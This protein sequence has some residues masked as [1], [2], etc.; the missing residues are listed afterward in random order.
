MKTT[1]KI[2]ILIFIVAG[3]AKE[4]ILEFDPQP[5]SF[6]AAKF[7]SP[8]TQNEY[9]LECTMTA[10][11]TSIISLS[12]FTIKYTIENNSEVDFKEHIYISLALV[13]NKPDF[14]LG[15]YVADYYSLL[16]WE[17]TSWGRTTKL[18]ELSKNDEYENSVNIADI[19]WISSISSAIQPANGNFYDL[20]QT[21]NFKFQLSI[22]IDDKDDYTTETPTMIYSN[23]LDL[24][25][26]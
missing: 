6:A 11:E 3:C 7:G 10:N 16:W 14:P 4:E 5:E 8:S 18:F 12:D 9:G 22:M 2:M 13:H 26:K 15:T 17:R 24:E 25:I 20:F 23:V 1:L 19:G 21:G